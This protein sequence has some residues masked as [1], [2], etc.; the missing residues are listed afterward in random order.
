MR[1]L[2]QAGPLPPVGGEVALRSSDGVEEAVHETRSRR[3]TA[4][5]RRA[6][7]LRPEIMMPDRRTGSAKSGDRFSRTNGSVCSEIMLWQENNQ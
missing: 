2:M 3:K 7:K 6:R 4:T 5:T 1:E